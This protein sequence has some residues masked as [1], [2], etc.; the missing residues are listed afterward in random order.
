MKLLGVLSYLEAHSH[1]IFERLQEYLVKEETYKPK[2]Q[3]KIIF[4][5]SQLFL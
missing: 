5:H 2:G 1:Q 3:L 4:Q